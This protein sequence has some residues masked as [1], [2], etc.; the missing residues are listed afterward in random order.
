MSA[1]DIIDQGCETEEKHRKQALEFR[2]PVLKACGACY[3][4]NSEIP[5]GLFCSADCLED[6]QRIEAAK[7]RNGT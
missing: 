3:Y 4:C 5:A 6:Y 2:Y 7:V 1:M